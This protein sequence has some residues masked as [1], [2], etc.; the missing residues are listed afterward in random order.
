M[1]SEVLSVHKLVKRFGPPVGGFMAVNDVSFHVGEGE[2]VGL[3]GPNGA[4]KTTTISMLLGLLTPTSGSIRYFGKDFSSNR[5]AVLKE[6]N[7]SSAY[8]KAPW[9]MKVWEHLYVFARIYEVPDPMPRIGSLLEAFHLTKFRDTLGGDLSSGNIARVNLCKAFINHPKLVLLDEPTSSLDPEIADIVRKYLLH[10]QDSYRTTILITSH[11]MA[12]IEELCDRVIFMNGGKILD[13][14][15]P[16][17]L[18]KKIASIRVRLMMKDG[19]KRTITYAKRKKLPVTVSGRYITVEVSE[20]NVAGLLTDLAGLGVEYTEIS[21]DKPTL[22][23]YFLG[24]VRH[25]VKSP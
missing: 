25:A 6:I 2:I 17:G 9:R 13:E 11:N 8:T 3:L 10:V 18:A 24:E 21:I 22:E 19:Q 1:T 12:E 15:T 14:D 20:Q 23:D 7:Y 5:E 16:E 4:G